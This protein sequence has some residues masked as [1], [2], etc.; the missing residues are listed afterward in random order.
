VAWQYGVSGPF[1]YA[2]GATIQVL[3]FGVLAIE[4]K[5]KAPAAHTICEIV[6]ARW[7]TRTHIVFL[8]FCFLT[9]II[10]TSMLLLGGSSVV[11]A[12]TGVNL[13]A[14]SFLIPL[15]V[16][17]YTLHGGLKAT[18]LASYLHSAVVHVVLVIF[19]FL[20]YVSS[21]KLGSP[22]QVHNLLR[23]V[24]HIPSCTEPLDHHGQACGPV[25]GNNGGSYLT[26]LSTGGL[27]FGIIN[28]VGNFG[29][30][31]VDNV[32]RQSLS[33]PLPSPLQSLKSLLNLS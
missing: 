13:Y 23:E 10:V 14:A 26:M 28:I 3:L 9:N 30:V 1:W 32:G 12:L 22:R 16:V 7:G 5:R 25:V 8:C 4:I 15:G 21:K 19:V 33:P 18:F 2:S 24:V 11:N 27:V 6:R 31:F 17:V 29:T 20:V